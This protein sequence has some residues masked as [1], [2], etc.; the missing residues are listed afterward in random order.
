MSRLG[1]SDPL[2]LEELITLPETLEIES[3]LNA[4]RAGM[5]DAGM[6]ANEAEE[7]ARRATAAIHHGGSVVDDLGD[8]GLYTERWV[9]LEALRATILQHRQS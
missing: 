6:T 9:V 8:A 5:L 4:I 2:R 3:L 7:A 1:E